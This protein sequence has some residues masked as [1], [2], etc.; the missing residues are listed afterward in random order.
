MGRISINTDIL[1]QPPFHT[2]TGKLVW[3]CLLRE[4]DA[5]NIANVSARAIAREIGVNEKTVR[6]VLSALEQSGI[7]E[8]TA[9]HS[10]PHLDPNA[11]RYSGRCIT[12]KHSAANGAKIRKKTK[13]ESAHESAHESATVAGRTSSTTLNFIDPLFADAF[14]SWLDY[15]KTQF[16]FE[17][18]TQRSLKAAYDEL[19][20][21]SG[22]DPHLAI[23]I[24]E[25]SMRNGWKGL[26]ELKNHGTKSTASPDNATARKESRDRL[27]SLATGVIS[28]NTD[29][30]LSLFNGGVA[31]PDDR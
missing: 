2:N 30:L 9:P 24:V 5:N 29:K 19:V 26:F 15:K 23:M 8:T 14:T 10:G 12:L 3:F 17:Y 22:N 18:K 20:R 31:D 25:Q 6:N 7:T 16:K 21:L 28:R 27:R 1:R 13:P 4:A 11:L